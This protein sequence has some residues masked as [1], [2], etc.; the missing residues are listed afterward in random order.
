MAF[1][2]ISLKR[3][4]SIFT[5]GFIAV[6]M[7]WVKYKPEK[8]DTIA[9]DDEPTVFEEQKLNVSYE[10]PPNH[11]EVSESEIKSEADEKSLENEVF[12]SLCDPVA[13]NVLEKQGAVASI[14]NDL[15]EGWRKRSLDY[16][17]SA[18]LNRL[19]VLLGS[20]HCPQISFLVEDD[21]QCTTENG[22]H[23][24]TS[25]FISSLTSSENDADIEEMME[26]NKVSLDS[27]KPVAS[28]DKNLDLD[29]EDAPFSWPKEV[30]NSV[31]KEIVEEEENGKNIYNTN[32]DSAGCYKP[33]DSPAAHSENYSFTSLLCSAIPY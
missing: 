14:R 3:S 20:E 18:E 26:E 25:S 28:P 5:G 22:I 12:S 17:I 11:K 4:W 10:S 29:S 13:K 2:L 27:L 9:T 30:E 23:T 6:V 8:N 15:L 21:T 31:K 7:I 24:P 16:F 19:N 1:S 33:A 32:C